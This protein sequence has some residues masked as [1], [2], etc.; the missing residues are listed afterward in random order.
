MNGNENDRENQMGGEY[1][2]L[3][4]ELFL[5][6]LELLLGN[7]L[8]MRKL[9]EMLPIGGAQMSEMAKAIGD[10]NEKVAVF[11]TDMRKALQLEGSKSSEALSHSDVK[12]VSDLDKVR[13]QIDRI[14]LIAHNFS[15]PF[16]SSLLF[17][18][19][20]LVCLKKCENFLD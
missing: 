15:I 1:Q 2:L 5:V 20:T 14:H 3:F 10:Q 12:K 6:L 4:L 8:R 7:E 19:K 13:F 16:S 18:K 9:K 17:A 11:L